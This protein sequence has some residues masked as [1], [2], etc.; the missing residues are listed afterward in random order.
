[1]ELS[2]KNRALSAELVSEQNKVKKLEDKLNELTSEQ[3]QQSNTSTISF[4]P[5][6][7]CDDVDIKVLMICD[8]YIY[9]YIHIY[10]YI[11]IY[12]YI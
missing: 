8:I 10:I 2:R 4:H 11:Y 9:T 1:M 5:S 7:D 6:S 12:I 3:V